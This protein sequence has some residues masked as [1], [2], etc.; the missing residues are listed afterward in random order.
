MKIADVGGYNGHA[1]TERRCSNH[2][3]K[4][5]ISGKSYLSDDL[6]IL[7]SIHFVERNYVQIAD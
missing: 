1:I 7:L 5:T 3:V 6:A 4:D 2:P